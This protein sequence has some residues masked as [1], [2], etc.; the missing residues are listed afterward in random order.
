MRAE[1]SQS[2]VWSNDL[3][4]QKSVHPFPPVTFAQR[5]NVPWSR[6]DKV[7][8]VVFVCLVS[9]IR[10]VPPAACLKFILSF[11]MKRKLRLDSHSWHQ[12]CNCNWDTWHLSF[13]ASLNDKS[14]H[15]LHLLI[16]VY[17]IICIMKC[18]AGCSRSMQYSSVYQYQRYTIVWPILHKIPPVL[19]AV[20]PD[21]T[22][23]IGNDCNIVHF[24]KQTTLFTLSFSLICC[25]I[26]DY[27]ERTCIYVYSQHW[28]DFLRHV[29][30]AICLLFK[31]V[32]LQWHKWEFLLVHVSYC[33]NVF[34]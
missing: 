18:T 7:D 29:N 3:S 25:F 2:E 4:V 24:S 14:H 1:R 16:Y 31:L 9:H 27:V 13:S 30:E 32:S 23:A 21:V 26:F 6:H 28:S 22:S 19:C 33:N 11:K 5:Q 15:W 17:V 12:W 34:W 20:Y 10:A 8:A